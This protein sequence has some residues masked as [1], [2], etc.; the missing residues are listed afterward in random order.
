MYNGRRTNIDFVAAALAFR[1]AADAGLPEAMRYYG[2]CLQNGRGVEK[3]PVS[4]ARYYQMAADL[5]NVDAMYDYGCCLASAEGVDHDPVAASRYFR[6]AAESGDPVHIWQVATRLLEGD[7]VGKDEVA[8][9]RYFLALESSKKVDR[10]SELAIMLRCG[11]NVRMDIGES[12]HW[13]RRC[14]EMGHPENLDQL[15]LC[16]EKGIGVEVDLVQAAR[17][18]ERAAKLRT[19]ASQLSLGV[20]HWRGIGGY[21]VDPREA[22][23]LWRLGGLDIPDSALTEDNANSVPAGG[24]ND[25]SS[26]FCTLTCETE[27]FSTNR[28]VA[29]GRLAGI[30]RETTNREPSPRLG[31]SFSFVGAGRAPDSPPSDARGQGHTPVGTGDLCGSIRSD[32]LLADRPPDSHPPRPGPTRESFAL[33]NSEQVIE[34]VILN[35]GRG[36][37]EFLGEGPPAREIAR[38][39]GEGILREGERCLEN[40]SEADQGRILSEQVIECDTIHSLLRVCAVCYTRDTF[41]YRRVNQFLRS[42]TGPAT[43]TGRNLGLYIG[44]LRECFCVSGGFSPLAW[45]RPAVVYRGAN[46]ALDILADYARRPDE[47]IR[48]QGFTSS[49]DVVATVR[50]I[51]FLTIAEMRASGNK[52]TFVERSNLDPLVKG[53]I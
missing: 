32:S 45:D 37:R 3:D 4:A 16:Y 21:S 41:L 13:F 14:A 22:V 23:R 6:M 25:R 38:L 44:L 47:L 39:A 31:D 35:D 29:E 27:E 12:L 43:E 9:R 15:A 42:S 20:F 30:T 2:M 50:L 17:I 49:R 1:A 51:G 5:G 40:G 11:W 53:S 52:L 33:C 28:R 19:R 18:Y 36:V 24:S 7:G 8:A 26:R 46:F 48:W 10:L 34:S